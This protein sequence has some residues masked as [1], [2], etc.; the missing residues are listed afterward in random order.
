MDRSIDLA[1]QR[2]ICD[3]SLLG[4]KAASGSNSVAGERRQLTDSDLSDPSINFTTAF[5]KASS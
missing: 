4:V 2:M 3:I 1:V 5:F